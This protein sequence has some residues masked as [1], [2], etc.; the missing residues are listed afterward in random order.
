MEYEQFENYKTQQLTDLKKVHYSQ[1]YSAI[2]RAW[3]GGD[4][5][6]LIGFTATLKTKKDRCGD[7]IDKFQDVTTVSCSLQSMQGT[8]RGSKFMS[9]V[10]EPLANGGWLVHGMDFFAS[11]DFKVIRLPQYMG[12]KVGVDKIVCGGEW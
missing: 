6:Q 10:Y 4:D 12:E 5:V 2:K 3:C 7:F 1:A 8:D 11:E 9:E